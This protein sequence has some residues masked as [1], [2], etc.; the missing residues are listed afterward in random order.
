MGKIRLLFEEQKADIKE[1]FLKYISTIISVFLF[2][3]I[4][5]FEMD[6]FFD[7]SDVLEQV[8]MFF[9]TYACGS[10]FI[11][12]ALK[13]NKIIM[14]VV[15][16]FVS[17]ILTLF[18]FNLDEWVSQNALETYEK[19]Y[20]LYILVLL[21]TALYIIIKKSELSFQRYVNTVVLN[22]IK[23]GVIFIVFNIGIVIILGIFN[24]LIVK[25]DVFDIMAKFEF[26]LMGILYFPYALICVLAKKEEKNKFYKVVIKYI[27][28]LMLLIAMCIIY[29]YILKMVFTLSVPKNEVFEICA[30]VFCLGFFVSTMAY[31][32]I[33]EEDTSGVYDK[34]IKY[35]KYG[36]IPMILLEIYAVGTR[37]M[38]YGMTEDRYIGVVFII[39]QV[40]YL[41]WE[42]IDKIISG[43]KKSEGDETGY[44]KNYEKLIFVAII[45]YIFTMLVPFT[46]IEYVCFSS[47]KNRME[48][49]IE[50]GDYSTAVSAIN[51]LKYNKYGEKYLDKNYSKNEI[52][53]MYSNYN[54]NK[55]S[56]GTDYRYHT[57]VSP[58]YEQSDIEISGYNR[59]YTFSYN[60]YD[61]FDFHNDTL[62]ID[63]ITQKEN[64]AVKIDNPKQIIENALEDYGYNENGVMDYYDSSKKE[65]RE[66]IYGDKKIVI[67]GISFYYYEDGRTINNLS[68]RGYVLMK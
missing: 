17:F 41:L 38:S 59:M 40:I 19:F 22:F 36:F 48:H 56:D 13:N 54:D 2:C 35:L 45:I 28:M 60:K 29:L 15:D 12:T 18:A 37:I 66:Y 30:S 5:I 32:Y 33:D 47:Q 16:A 7:S 46:N 44:G 67:T 49:A 27:L 3:I 20:I 23:W 14:Y 62:T 58:N 55:G 51:K 52:E 50:K 63:P 65:A 68:M 34:I 10:F 26:L 43:F 4:M 25:I 11:E 1:I 21:G 61:E 57:Y 39:A 31:A 8:I 64:L 24:S 42:P 53:N 9:I 6:D